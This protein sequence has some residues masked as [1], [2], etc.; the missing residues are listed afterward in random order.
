MPTVR[1]KLSVAAALVCSLAVAACGGGGRGPAAKSTKSSNNP[2]L[3]L[4]RCMRSHGVPD[5]P[6]PTVGPGGQEGMSVLMSPGSS[7]VTVEGVPLS[8]PAFRAAEKTC[9]MFGAGTGRPPI[10]GAQ[11]HQMVE[12]SECMRRHGVKDFPDPTFPAGGGV[13]RAPT[14]GLDRSSPTFQSAVRACNRS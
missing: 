7:T 13:A 14:P 4:A 6:D 9:R 10:T 8:G 12:F 3:A 11:K 1:L 5:F 2:Q